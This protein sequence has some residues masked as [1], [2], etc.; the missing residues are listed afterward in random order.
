MGSSLFPTVGT[1]FTHKYIRFIASQ[2][3]CD[4]RPIKIYINVKY[5]KCNSVLS[6]VSSANAQVRVAIKQEDDTKLQYTLL[7]SKT[8]AF[9]KIT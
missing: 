7:E 3:K 8:K 1:P 6:Q 4:E 9:W 2:S 5:N